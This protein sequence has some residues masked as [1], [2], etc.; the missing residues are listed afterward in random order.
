[1]IIKRLSCYVN[2][3]AVTISLVT[4]M[5]HIIF[6][7]SEYLTSFDKLCMVDQQN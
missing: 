6:A 2:I 5:F 4:Q 1:M 7:I 3:A